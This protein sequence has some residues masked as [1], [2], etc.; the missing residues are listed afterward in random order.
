MR[1]RIS[2]KLFGAVNVKCQFVWGGG[3]LV[4]VVVI[5]L[6]TADYFVRVKHNVYFLN[7][8]SPSLF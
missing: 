8:Y 3:C 2:S 4:I 6:M 1:R 7:Y 5:L